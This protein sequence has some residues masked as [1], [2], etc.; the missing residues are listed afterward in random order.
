MT[1]AYMRCF[2]IYSKGGKTERCKSSI[3]DK[4]PALMLYRSFAEMERI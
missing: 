3:Y 1:P 4:P 2:L